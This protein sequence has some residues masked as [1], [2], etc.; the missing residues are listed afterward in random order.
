MEL[1]ALF[2]RLTIPSH[3]SGITPWPHCQTVDPALKKLFAVFSPASRIPPWAC[4]GSEYTTGGS[5]SPPLPPS[6]SG[7][8]YR[9]LQ[10][11]HHTQFPCL[12]YQLWCRPE[13]AIPKYICL[14]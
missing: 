2:V 12:V 8:H 11:L 9:N 3:Y 4:S 10:S 13:N 14:A 7:C 1:P 6:T 5:C